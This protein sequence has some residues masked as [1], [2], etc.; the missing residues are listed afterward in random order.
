MK[1]TWWWAAIGLMGCC[2]AGSGRAAEPAAAAAEARP[3]FTLAE[4]LELGLEQ[5][6]AARNPARASGR[7]GRRC[8][9]N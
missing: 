5:A 1:R 8:C 4:C 3:A 6:A 7:C 9:R 2:V